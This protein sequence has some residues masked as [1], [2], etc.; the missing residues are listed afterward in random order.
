MRG[1]LP[2]IT[3]SLKQ[4]R[5]VVSMRWKPTIAIVCVLLV[6]AGLLFWWH[7]YR[8]VQRLNALRARAALGNPKA[9]FG[10][11]S[12]YYLGKG[13]PQDYAEA[14]RW[15]KMAAEHGNAKG[16]FDLGTVYNEGIGLPPDYIEASRWFRKAADQN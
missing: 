1:K 11:A 13:V 15:Y 8:P 10:L 6:C 9:Q 16:Q 14:L 12:A 2:A 3:L 5:T 7:I 4:S